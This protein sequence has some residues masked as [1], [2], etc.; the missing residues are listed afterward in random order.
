MSEAERTV[1]VAL[2]AIITVVALSLG[3]AAVSAL[4]DL[5]A[6]PLVCEG[7]APQPWPLCPR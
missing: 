5:L 7:A 1:V 6:H 2:A 3:D 4:R